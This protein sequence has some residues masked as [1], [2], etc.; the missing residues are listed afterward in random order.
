VQIAIN[1]NVIVKK[2]G[3]YYFNQK[4]LAQGLNNTIDVIAN[5]EKLYEEIIAATIA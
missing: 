3:W 1:K 5:D 4:K 2:G